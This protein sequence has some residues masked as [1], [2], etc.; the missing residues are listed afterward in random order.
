MKKRTRSILEE[1]ESMHHARDSRYVIESRA[2]NI[3]ASAVN[4]IELMEEV[5][6]TEEVDDLTR[7]LLNSIRQKDALKFKRSLG[8]V[9]ESK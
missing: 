3:I 9:N 8:R 1:L 6:T 5:Y 7:K 4:L 2:E